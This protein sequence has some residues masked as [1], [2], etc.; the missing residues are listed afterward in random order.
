MISRRTERFLREF[1]RLP[2]AIR[3]QATV[4]YRLFQD[5]PQHPSLRFRQVH[6]VQPIYSARVGRHYRAVGIR[7]ADEMIWFW[8]G[9]HAEYDQL[10]AHL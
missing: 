7:D 3:Q 9:S 6:A 2:P 10:L 1:A 8:I 4:A 5:N